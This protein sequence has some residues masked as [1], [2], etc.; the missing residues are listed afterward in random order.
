M[1]WTTRLPKE[2]VEPD[3]VDE[4]HY[5]CFLPKKWQGEG[6]VVNL[7]IPECELRADLPTPPGAEPAVFI[8]R[9]P[10]DR[11]KVENWL[12]LACQIATKQAAALFFACDTARQAE[13]AAQ[14]ASKL[15]PD[16]ERVALERLHEPHA[17]ARSGLH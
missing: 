11:Q 1:K 4:A 6:L 10:A 7:L 14:M 17:D 2:M 5:A 12:P 16:H 13:R 3:G 8:N 9:P 15:L